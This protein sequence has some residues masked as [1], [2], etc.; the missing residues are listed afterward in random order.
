[1][2]SIHSSD[3]SSIGNLLFCQTKIMCPVN[4]SIALPLEHHNCILITPSHFVCSGFTSCVFFSI[5]SITSPIIT[6]WPMIFIGSSLLI[7]STIL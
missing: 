3:C 6:G 4:I 1:M 7:K 5:K 2:K